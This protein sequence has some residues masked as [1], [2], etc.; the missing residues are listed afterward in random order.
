MHNL[1]IGV[2]EN[3]DTTSPMDVYQWVAYTQQI[4][5]GAVLKNYRAVLLERKQ[6][7]KDIAVDK[8]D[9]GEL[10]GLSTDDLWDWTKKDMVGYDGNVYLEIDKCVNFERDL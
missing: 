8:W 3:L 4:L 7:T 5:R 10:K 6:S 9:I 2:F 1:T